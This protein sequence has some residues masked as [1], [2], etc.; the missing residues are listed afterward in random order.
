MRSKDTTNLIYS[1]LRRQIISLDI[2]PGQLV[3]EQDICDRFEASR[4]PVHTALERLCD[5]GLMEFVP[6]KGVRSTLLRF[7]DIYQWILMRVTLE[8]KVIADFAKQGDAFAL[9]RGSH[10]VRNQEI[11]LSQDT[12]EASR[13]YAL[14]SELHQRWFTE[15]GLPL[16]WQVIQDSEVYYTRFRM[17]D[18]VEIHN[19]KEILKEHKVLLSLI[20]S[21]AYTQMEE[22]VKYHLFGGIRRMQTSLRQEL[23]SYFSD[24]EDIGTYLDKALAVRRPDCLT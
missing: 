16:F 14:D 21:Q 23:A 8:T 17:L 20:E 15:M 2:R 7:A 13:F 24:A 11:L 9:E 1:S 4:T 22:V 6:Y 5:A 12:F 3:R 18:I 10:I 19:F